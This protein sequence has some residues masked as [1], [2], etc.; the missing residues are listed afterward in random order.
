MDGEL[1]GGLGV[2]YEATDGKSD[3]CGRQNS[4]SSTYAILSLTLHGLFLSTYHRYESDEIR[5][6][7]WFQ[8]D[9]IVVLEDSF[10]AGAT[11]LRGDR[12]LSFSQ[13][14]DNR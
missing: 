5:V 1:T 11:T 12:D 2:E 8:E 7:R 3:V 4:L 9:L 6:C 13:P 10:A 14:R